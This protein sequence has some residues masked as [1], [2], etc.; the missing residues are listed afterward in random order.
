MEDGRYGEGSE[1]R[2]G[3]LLLLLKLTSSFKAGS[4]SLCYRTASASKPQ[5]LESTS[6]LT[7]YSLH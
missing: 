1:E 5:I 2:K 6:I 4:K 3:L 7:N